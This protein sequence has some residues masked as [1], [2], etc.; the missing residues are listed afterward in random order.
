METWGSASLAPGFLLL[1]F[2]AYESAIRF[3]KF[4]R[5]SEVCCLIPLFFETSR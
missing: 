2:R 5:Q 1:P 3:V 4:A